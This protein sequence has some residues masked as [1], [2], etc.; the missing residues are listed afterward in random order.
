MQEDSNQYLI[1]GLLI[2]FILIFLIGI[3][4]YTKPD[5]FPGRKK[6][7]EI[8][9]ERFFHISAEQ[10]GRKIYDVKYQLKEEDEIVS[11]GILEQGKITEYR[12]VKNNTEY[13]LT[14][15]SD[16]YYYSRKNCTIKQSDCTIQAQ[17]IAKIASRETLFKDKFVALIS[18]ENGTIRGFA[19][20]IKENTDRIIGITTKYKWLPTPNRLRE[21]ACYTYDTPD[22]IPGYY[23]LDFDLQ[24]DHN[25]EYRKGDKITLYL[26]DLYNESGS[27][28]IKNNDVVKE[29][30]I[31]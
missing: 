25:Y 4:I 7:Q 26:T 2:T 20:C 13:Y 6:T 21:T 3:I 9:P 27:Q 17:R 23:Y 15:D 18:V 8:V 30:V 19:F 16:D 10:A 22:L 12:P 5:L 29:V 14:L 28:D 11:E 1:I 31:A 24:I